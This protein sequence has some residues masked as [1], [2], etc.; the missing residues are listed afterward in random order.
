VPEI[1]D[2]QYQEAIDAIARAQLALQPKQSTN[3]E[4][5]T[6]MQS[7]SAGALQG[8]TFN[9]G[10][11]IGAFIDE[12]RGKG[13]YQ[14]QLSAAR[15][16]MGDFEK[17]NPNAYLAGE[18]AGG[19]ASAAIPVGRA[20]AVGRNAAGFQQAIQAGMR[21]AK[22]AAA[23][24]AVAGAGAAEGNENIAPSAALGG[25][26]GAFG[27]LLLGYGATV[28]APRLQSLASMIGMRQSQAQDI[29]REVT[30]DGAIFK[31]QPS[32]GQQQVNLP[33]EVTQNLAA[34]PS[35]I[36]STATKTFSNL[37]D[38]ITERDLPADIRSLPLEERIVYR[39]I[40][41][42]S[43]AEDTAR[44]MVE[45]SNFGLNL[46]IAG[47]SRSAGVPALGN[48]VAQ[49][50]KA[51]ITAQSLIENLDA[52]ATKAIDK[53]TRELAPSSA[54]DGGRQL[55]EL[56]QQVYEQA[57]QQRR[58]SAAPLY[59][60]V[61]NPQN[62]LPGAEIDSFLKQ[63]PYAADVLR[64]LNND[65]TYLQLAAK[66]FKDVGYDYADDLTKTVTALPNNNLLKLHALRTNLSEIAYTGGRPP[67]PQQA[68]A[69]SALKELD[70]LIERRYPDY[71]KAKQL[72]STGSKFLE[73][74][75]NTYVGFARNLNE[76]NFERAGKA[77]PQLNIDQ[78]KQLRGMYRQVN[79]D[80]DALKE[81]G[82]AE[83]RRTVFEAPIERMDKKMTSLLTGSLKAKQ[84][85][86]EILGKKDYE[87]TMAFLDALDGLPA[88]RS[89]FGNSATAPRLQAQRMLEDAGAINDAIMT[90]T[91][92]AQG[93]V[94]G[95]AGGVVRSLTRRDYYS[96][97]QK[98]PEV[99]ENVINILYDPQRGRQFIDK[100][101]KSKPGSKE[102]QQALAALLVSAGAIAQQEEQQ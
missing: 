31:A 96:V 60:K 95:L 7:F 73:D 67:E 18:I 56:S 6:Q 10:D 72:Y 78:I 102:S 12:M 29:V 32:T 59:Q 58:A 76:G 25:T 81:A 74:L 70:T 46:P 33:N 15:S 13:N 20:V 24:G 82:L 92:V 14:Q 41:G 66:S 71:L 22:P 85:W 88:V 5:K 91:D 19:I 4:R 61:V 43:G 94:A 51:A 100:I 65:P 77:I 37:R 16:N 63:N 39:S 48:V 69:T 2:K 55:A 35:N 101:I 90:V 9:F 79:P 45:G 52:Q 62:N 30:P 98:N 47:S 44:R 11:E 75:D 50:G 87:K 86:Q 84:N 93:G 27:G 40:G 23:L 36:G 28:A 3:K 64:R 89:T 99:A 80:V 49:E 26:A 83:I 34:Q 42:Q 57:I 8:A 68:A 53:F 1:D 97:L 54:K 38:F 21:A 17:D